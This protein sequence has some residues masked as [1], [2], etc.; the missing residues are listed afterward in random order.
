MSETSRFTF[1]VSFIAF[2]GFIGGTAYLAAFPDLGKTFEVSPAFIKLSLTLYFVGLILGSLFSGP[3]S[4]IY[5]RKPILMSFLLLF[6]CSSLL[7]AL[8]P[9][10]SWFL[11]G[12]LLQGIG[13]SGG[14][15]IVIATVAD[16]YTGKTYYKILS[17]ILIMLA[18]GPGVAP[19]LGSFILHFFEWR[20]IFYIFAFLGIIEIIMAYSMGIAPP[21][22]RREIKETLHEHLVFLKNPLF[23]YYWI[24]VGVLYGAFYAFAVMS[25]YIFLI[26]YKWSTLDFAWVGLSLAFGNGL[27]V[28]LE[29][30]L[31]EKLGS[32]NI[33]FTGL[34]S[35]S[36]ALLTLFLLGSP[37]HG[38]W[39]LLLATLFMIGANLTSS[40]LTAE[41]VKIDAQFTGIGSSLINLSK[42][43]H[44]C[45]VLYL[46]IFLPETIQVVT[47]FL[48]AA[49]LICVLGYLKIRPH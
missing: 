34:M 42:T 8:S 31:I 3:L 18:L 47:F 29:N 11:V 41:A 5:G 24:M 16:K 36:I 2:L 20:M 25:P 22:K 38:E 21:R 39:L 19:I 26:H 37:L 13:N 35:M 12:R 6:I 1:F 45:L 17:F 15:I 14:P 4:D 40:C 9:S 32:Y 28:F 7:C 44:A 49:F 27:G 33:I 10:I 43:L 46:A 23:R 30:E 48:L